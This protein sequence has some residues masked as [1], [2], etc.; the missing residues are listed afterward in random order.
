MLKKASQS[1]RVF[2]T[3]WF[4]K[5]AGKARITDAELCSAIEQVMRGQADDLGVGF[6]KKRLNDNRHRAIILA[7]AG[8]YWIYAYMFAKNDRENIAPDELADFKK[9]AKFYALKTE[10]EITSELKSNYLLEIC[11]DC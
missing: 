9:L 3:A 8:R 4:A 10:A 6:Y 1:M 5:E 7:K 2:K 11:H